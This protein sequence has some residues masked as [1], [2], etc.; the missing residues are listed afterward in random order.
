MGTG[1]NN[2][3][4]LTEN[5]PKVYDV[6]KDNAEPM[7]V[8][9]TL[10]TSFRQVCGKQNGQVVAYSFDSL[11]SNSMKSS[12]PHSGC[13]E[14]DIA[15][16]LDTTVPD[17][18]K[19]QGGIAIAYCIAG[20][21][22]DRQI[23]NG[24]NGKG[25]QEEVSYTLNTVDRH[26]VMSIE[27]GQSAWTASKASYMTNFAKEM[28]NTLVATDWKDPPVLVTENKLPEAC[29]PMTDEDSTDKM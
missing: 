19:N 17:P 27:G 5:I 24:G 25:V 29:A 18:S 26:A 11:S 14:V 4:I 23:Q 28:A 6:N 2:V 3:P 9:K 1:G 21:T 16:T 13:R 20:N 12:N 15:K 8:S 7:D 10:D 22:I